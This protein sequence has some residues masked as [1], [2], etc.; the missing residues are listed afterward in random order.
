MGAFKSRTTGLELSRTEFLRWKQA[1]KRGPKHTKKSSPQTFGK[2]VCDL[3]DKR[4]WTWFTT[5]TT[6]YECSLPSAR[7]LMD[8]TFSMWQELSGR[9]CVMFWV[10]E[11][12]ELRN[13][14][15]M[16]AVVSMPP[17]FT[18]KENFAELVRTYR[19]ACGGEKLPRIQ[20]K[21]FDRKR[22]ASGYLTK[23]LLKSKDLADWDWCGYNLN[24]RQI[25]QTEDQ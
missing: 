7:R 25:K 21:P 5:F 9:S 6:P 12:N 15:H 22:N 24:L 19:N 18:Q 23:Y 13:G 10:C 16:H 2:G 1:N 3:L 20:C 17:M 8:R 11:R 14:Y 4:D